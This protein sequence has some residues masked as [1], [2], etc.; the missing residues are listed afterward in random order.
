MNKSTPSDVSIREQHNKRFTVV[1]GISY[2]SVGSI[3]AYS[4]RVGVFY[5][6]WSVG[7][8]GVSVETRD[9]FGAY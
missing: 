4:E 1:K 2:L 8:D 9:G 5:G 3:C 6:T 7:N